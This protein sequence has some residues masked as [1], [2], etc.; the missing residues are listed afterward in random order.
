MKTAIGILGGLLTF[1]ALSFLLVAAALGARIDTPPTGGGN[2]LNNKVPAAYHP[3]ITKAS[4]VCKE[5]ELT[6]PLL[7]AQLH[8]E[9]GFHTDAHSDAGAE[10]PAQFMPG[11]WA[12]WGRDDDHNGR[13]DPHDIGDAVMAQGRF[14]CSL[15]HKAK[16]SA[17][18]GDPRGLALAGYNAGWAAVEKHQGIPPYQQT[19]HYVHIILATMPLYSDGGIKVTGTDDESRA[20]RRA[21]GQVGVPYAW[22]GGDGG[23][24]TRGYCDGTNGYLDGTCV[25]RF[26]TGFDCS[27]LVQYAYWPYTQLPRRAD[28]QYDATSNH[29]VSR[30]DLRQGD[31]VFWAHRDGHIYHVALYAGHGKIV[32][33]PRT[34]KKVQVIAMSKAMP[35]ADYKGATRP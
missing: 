12:T 31:L 27:G 16:N 4:E 17:I 32:E 1:L 14:M 13:S 5:P 3:W 18:E 15:I 2:G 28:Q 9:S 23:G 7:A 19:R 21:L 29:P 10:G 30:H 33:A 34:G 20:L 25:A 8:Q 11:T 35:A 26:T 22:G 6:P 24:P